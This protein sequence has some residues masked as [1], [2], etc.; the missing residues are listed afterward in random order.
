MVSIYF[1]CF[2]ANKKTKTPFFIN[3]EHFPFA[4]SKSFV[5]NANY[6]LDTSNNPNNNNNNDKN[7]NNNDSAVINY[8]DKN[9]VSANGS[10]EKGLHGQLGS[11]SG[12][13]SLGLQASLQCLTTSTSLSSLSPPSLSSSMCGLNASQKL[14]ARQTFDGIDAITSSSLNTSTHSD[15]DARFALN[16]TKIAQQESSFETSYNTSGQNGLELNLHLMPSIDASNNGM[17]EHRDSKLKTNKNIYF[18]DEL[19]QFH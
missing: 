2:S 17:M 10:F 9:T 7:N 3:I 14:G 12:A 1:T 18:V 4:V 13:V 5:Q 11:S 8:N 15:L 16:S 6:F 19:R